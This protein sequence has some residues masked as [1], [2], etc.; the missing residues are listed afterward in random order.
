MTI[1]LSITSNVNSTWASK[2]AN[3]AG[4]VTVAL[5]K[6]ASV[7]SWLSLLSTESRPAVATPRPVNTERDGAPRRSLNLEDYKK[8]RGLIWVN[9]LGWVQLIHATA[10]LVYDTF[11]ARWIVYREMTLSRLAAKTSE[12]VNIFYTASS[13]YARSWVSKLRSEA[14]VNFP[15]NEEEI[16]ITP[17][18]GVVEKHWTVILTV[19]YL[20]I[21]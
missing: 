15:I 7:F 9:N 2:T 4:I 11:S 5:A 21:F 6:S 13:F 17:W 16:S 12:V 20:L 8:R 14:F 18:T 1:A 3:L 10:Y 19:F